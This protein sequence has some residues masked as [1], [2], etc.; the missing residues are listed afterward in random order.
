MGKRS[1]FKRKKH[2]KYYS[3]ETAMR[4]LYPHLGACEWFCEPCAGDGRMIRW[5]T[6]A[7]HK[8]VAAWDIKPHANGIELRDARTARAA[9]A[10]VYISNPPWTRELLHAIIDNLSG[11]RPTWLL[12]DADWAYTDAAY[13]LVQRCSLIVAVG[14]LKWIPGSKHGSLENCAWYRFDP[15]HTA[16]P[17]FIGRSAR[18]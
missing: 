12:F 3:P 18:A 6:G 14:R 9:G 8:F 10:T 1:N 17:R 4:F 16:G 7:G 2:D 11:H 15:G 13:D 5:L